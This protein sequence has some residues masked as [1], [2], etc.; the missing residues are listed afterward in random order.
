MGCSAASAVSGWGGGAPAAVLVAVDPQVDNWGPATVQT[1]ASARD[2]GAARRW[3]RGSAVAGWGNQ[4]S[5]CA[6]VP[7]GG[8]RAACV[9]AG[10][11]SCHGAA[12][13]GRSVVG[14]W[15]AGKAVW[16]NWEHAGTPG[17]VEGNWGGCGTPQVAGKQEVWGAAAQG[18][19][20]VTSVV[21]KGSRAAWGAAD[22]DGWAA[23]DAEGASREMGAVASSAT[24]HAAVMGTGAVLGSGGVGM[25]SWVPGGVGAG[26]QALRGA[27]D[28]GKGRRV[29]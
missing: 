13:A 12:G 1:G 3:S 7:G 16:G 11:C 21:E 25:S 10:S 18:G 22:E 9:G 26:S 6:L 4:E 2:A 29:T 5:L 24:Q 19:S 17:A 14:A 15:V 23:W 8:S 20:W 27:W 28:A